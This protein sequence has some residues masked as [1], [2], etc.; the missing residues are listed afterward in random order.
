M[1]GGVANQLDFRRRAPHDRLSGDLKERARATSTG[2]RCSPCCLELSLVVWTAGERVAECLA[3]L[4]CFSII[5]PADH[6]I[7]NEG[8]VGRR[9]EGHGVWCVC[10]G[11]R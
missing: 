4:P 9:R 6:V 8:G 5:F 7:P 10:W 1:G 11:G 3:K 2:I